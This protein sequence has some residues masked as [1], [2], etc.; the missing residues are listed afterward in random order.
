MQELRQV[1]HEIRSELSFIMSKTQKPFRD[2]LAVV[3]LTVAIHY[4]FHAP[5]DKILWDVDEHVSC[6]NTCD[7]ESRSS[8]LFFPFSLLVFFKLG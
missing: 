5:I 7:R 3:E 8:N 2:S 6:F 4:V 1:A